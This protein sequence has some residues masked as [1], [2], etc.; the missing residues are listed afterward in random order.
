M[1]SHFITLGA[2]CSLLYQCGLELEAL[3]ENHDICSG[4]MTETLTLEH[5]IYERRALVQLLPSALQ[6]ANGQRDAHSCLISSLP[7]T[8]GL[9]FPVPDK[10]HFSSDSDADAVELDDILALAAAVYVFIKLNLSQQ[11]GYP[12]TLTQTAYSSRR[13]SYPAA[14]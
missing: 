1:S 4:V 7:P 3:F 14:A 12:R 2:A 8:S 9:S 5:V 13:A 10:S 11:Q 6:L